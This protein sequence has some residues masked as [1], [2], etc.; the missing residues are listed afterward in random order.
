[1]QKKSKSNKAQDQKPFLQDSLVHQKPEKSKFNQFLDRQGI[2]ISFKRYFIDALGAMA[3]GLFASLLI[4]TILQTMTML[5]PAGALK[6]NLSQIAGFATQAT[7]AAMAIAIGYALKAP[8]LVLFSLAGV[9]LAANNLG[10]AGGPLAVFFIA[11]I[12]CEIGKL[13]SKTTAVDI[14]LTPLVTL[15]SGGLSAALLAPAIGSM[16]NKIGEYVVSLTGQQPLIMGILVSVI[17]GILLTLPISSA[18]IAASFGLVGLAGGAGLA[19]C[20][21]QMVGFAVMSYKE[22]G[23]GGLLAQGL[24]TSMLQMP[25]IV[26]KPILFLP[27]II[28]S[29]ITGP[30]ATVLFK[31][32]MNGPAIASGMGTSGMVGPIGQVTGWFTPSEIATKYG[33][34][35]LNP[36]IMHWVQL[37]LV[38][39]VLPA[40]LCYFISEVFRKLNWIESGDLKITLN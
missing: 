15:L 31:M 30:I 26:R 19:G 39:I 36:S 29:A 1:M 32:E 16:A 23:L 38:C 11:I 34:M 10:G 22:N 14:I 5:V 8:A 9:G 40:V 33:A 18:A 24:G 20:S 21:A 25:N 37:I 12:A 28:T 27:S 7:G 13:V 4:G 17:M 6:D 2:E 3:L 35:A